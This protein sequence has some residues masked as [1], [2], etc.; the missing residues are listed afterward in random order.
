MLLE[1]I[2]SLDTSHGRIISVD[3]RINNL[4]QLDSTLR[5]E[6]MSSN[7]QLFIGDLTHLD[8]I[9]GLH[10]PNHPASNPTFDMVLIPNPIPLDPSSHPSLPSSLASYLSPPPPAAW[11]F[12]STLASTSPTLWPEYERLTK[13]EMAWFGSASSSKTNG[14]LRRK[15]SGHRLNQQVLE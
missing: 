4:H 7:I 8:E 13:M 12:S 1:V 6:G 3:D 10:D 15:A 11:L 2:K 9:A 14:H 5:A